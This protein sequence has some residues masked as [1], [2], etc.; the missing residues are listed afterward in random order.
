[1][2]LCIL[3]SNSVKMKSVDTDPLSIMSRLNVTVSLWQRQKREDARTHTHKQIEVFIAPV[4]L[5]G[6]MFG[7]SAQGNRDTDCAAVLLSHSTIAENNPISISHY[8]IYQEWKILCL[9]V[10][11]FNTLQ[12]E[13]EHYKFV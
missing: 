3:Y 13:Q 1:M 9:I 10:N 2:C 11:A 8:N 5:I 6:M 7:V 4:H 12:K